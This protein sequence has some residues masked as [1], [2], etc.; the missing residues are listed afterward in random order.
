M[1]PMFETLLADIPDALIAEATRRTGDFLVGFVGLTIDGRREDG[2]LKGSGTLVRLGATHGVLTARHVL[3]AL[4]KKGPIGLVLPKPTGVP[5]PPGKPTILAESTRRIG[6]DR[7]PVESEGPDLAMLLLAPGDVEW[8]R[9]RKSFF[10]LQHWRSAILNDQRDVAYQLHALSGFPDQLTSELGPQGGYDQVK[11]FF[12][13]SFFS[14]ISRVPAADDF[15]Y[16]NLDVGY[17]GGPSDPPRSFGGFSGGGL[18][19]IELRGNSPEQIKFGN[20]LLSGVAFYQSDLINDQRLIKCHWRR[21]V[22]ERMFEKI[23]QSTS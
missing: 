4:P 5:H 7:S 22:Y 1:S 16:V 19:H 3:D 11:A 8:L 21:S 12:G 13:L 15:D 18:W 9:P 6:F 20:C 10:D 14:F 17:G 23:S 2:C